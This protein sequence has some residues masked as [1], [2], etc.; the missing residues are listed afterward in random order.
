MLTSWETMSRN[1]WHFWG[2]T[3]SSTWLQQTMSDS[4]NASLFF[5][6]VCECAFIRLLSRRSREVWPESSVCVTPHRHTQMWPSVIS[7]ETAVSFGHG[8]LSFHSPLVALRTGLFVNSCFKCKCC[9]QLILFFLQICKLVEMVLFGTQEQMLA[10]HWLSDSPLALTLEFS[11]IPLSHCCSPLL[12]L[13][14]VWN[15]PAEFERP[16]STALFAAPLIDSS[17][18]TFNSMNP[19]KHLDLLGNICIFLIRGV[20][21]IICL[22]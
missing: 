3:L 13:L 7:P 20:V 8:F 5:V 14:C 16:L 11:L 9:M 12:M 10:T 2:I 22:F 6:C 15:K 17:S 18:D 19:T 4:R 21:R 1:S